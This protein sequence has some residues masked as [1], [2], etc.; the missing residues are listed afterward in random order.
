MN[1]D[2]N[3]YKIFLYLFEEKSIS[4]TAAKLYVSQ[5][6]ISYSLKELESQLGYTLFY[7]NSKGIEPTNEA[8]EL[9]SYVSTAF[10]IFKDAEEHIKNLNDLNIGCIRIGTPSHIGVS[11]LSSY[12]A[13]F[14]KLYPGIKFEIISKST[15][16]MV[17]M[18]ETRKLDFIVDTLPIDSKKKVTK[19]TVAKLKNC[20]AY[21]KNSMKNVTIETE[22][23]LQK[24]PLVLPSVAS[25]IRFKLDEYM[26][27]KNINLTP[28]VESWTNEM[29]VELVK[30]GIGIGYFI[31]NL[32][33]S[34]NDSDNFEIIEFDDN[35]PDVD[36]CCVY[37][38]DFL[39]AA[40]S[41]FIELL[42]NKSDVD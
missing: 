22:K 14:R 42:T 15:K 19:I 37:I 11:Y 18:L 36:I 13:E 12:I 4:K 3:L 27:S 39:T 23:D 7:R 33:I 24:Y 1:I 25:S 9:Y 2:Y 31:K 26:E 32:I 40:S 10:N 29:M 38:D 5:P 16:D 17:E 8:K 6:A 35:L 41:K 20:F 34:Q 28:T 30:K 21:N